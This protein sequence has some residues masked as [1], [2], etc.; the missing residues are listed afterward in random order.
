M[1]LVVPVSDIDNEF[2]DAGERS[3]ATGKFNLKFPFSARLHPAST[4]SG[5]EQTVKLT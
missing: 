2:D 4:P 3:I 1:R 5:Y